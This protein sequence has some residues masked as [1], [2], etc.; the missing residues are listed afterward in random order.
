MVGRCDGWVQWI[1]AVGG[2]G[3]VDGKGCGMK[4]VLS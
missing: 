4:C 2:H 1:D 3:D